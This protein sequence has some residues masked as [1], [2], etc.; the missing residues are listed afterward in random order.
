MPTYSGCQNEQ[1]ILDKFISVYNRKKTFNLW[2]WLTSGKKIVLEGRK[3]KV[4]AN[5]KQI[6]VKR[7]V[8]PCDE[9]YDMIA[10]PTLPEQALNQHI[11][12]MLK[13]CHRNMSKCY[14]YGGVFYEKFYSQEPNDLLAVT[15]LRRQFVDPKTKVPTTSREFSKVYLHFRGTFPRRYNSC[16]VP[17][18]AEVAENLKCVS[19]GMHKIFLHALDICLYVYV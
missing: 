4:P 3:W 8:L 1:Q 10:K 6:K 16:F 18:V 5:Q 14:G 11:F 15:K 19:S 13:I 2:T 12:S 17:Q 7:V 9:P